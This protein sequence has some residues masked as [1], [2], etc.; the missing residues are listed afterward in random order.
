[1]PDAPALVIEPAALSDPRT[2]V[3]ADIHL[4]LGATPDRPLGPPEAS[5]DQ[6]ARRLVELARST[7]ADAV[8]IAGD[9][10][11]PIVGTPPALRPVVFDFFAEL[12]REG[13]TVVL[14]LG[15]HDVGIVRDLPREV[16][17]KEVENDRS[18]CGRGADDRMFCVPGD[19]HGIRP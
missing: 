2:L 13:L 7:R 17:V 5:A 10:K 15:N 3:V 18:Q 12:L 19:D 9:A 11:H 8:V 14:V 4:G 16:L 1:M 6:L